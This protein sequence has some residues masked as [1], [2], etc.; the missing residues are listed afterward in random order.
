MEKLELL[1]QIGNDICE[2]CGPD[3]DCELEYDDCYRIE[4]ALATL[5]EYE[6]EMGG[7]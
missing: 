5:D 3:R 4:S 6:S 7:G 2:G 1:Q